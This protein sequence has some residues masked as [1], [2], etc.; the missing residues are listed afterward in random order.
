[1]TQIRPALLVIAETELWPNLLRVAHETGCRVALVNAR[2]SERSFRRYRF[3]RPFMRRVL[4]N[5][6]VICA[7]TETDAERFRRLDAKPASVVTAGNLK[8]DLR[9]PESGA[10]PRLMEKMLARAERRPILVAASTMAGEEPLV[11]EAW[12]AVRLQ[13]PSALLILAPRHPARFESVAQT[14]SRARHSFAR[15]SALKDGEGAFADQLASSEILLLDSIGELTGILEMA[16]V[17]FVG[18]SLVPTGGHNLLEPAYWAKPIV[19]GPHMGNFRD[20]AHLFLQASAAI[21]VRDA[22]HL[23]QVLLNLLAD[24]PG[25]RAMGER[26]KRLLEQESGATRRVLNEI[27][28]LLEAEVPLRAGA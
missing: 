11:L 12:K 17:V 10:W 4:G 8:F 9:P 21:S 26:A 1:M 18:G 5:V 22:E 14:L 20:I 28:R 23:S 16:D 27:R 6:D 24:P 13:Y 25:R 15:R 2:L 19:F 3:A 7:Q